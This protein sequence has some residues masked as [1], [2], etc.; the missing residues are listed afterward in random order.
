M[1]VLLNV[2]WAQ[3]GS[4]VTIVYNLTYFAVQTPAF[5][6]A[7]SHLLCRH[8]IVIVSKLTY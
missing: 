2:F 3:H 5:Y 8:Q 6:S 7:Q 1:M 4:K